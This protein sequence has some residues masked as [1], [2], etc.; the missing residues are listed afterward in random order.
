[1]SYL[2]ININNVRGSL[3]IF[4]GTEDS[5]WW[6]KVFVAGWMG[7]FIDGD[8]WMGELVDI[9]IVYLWRVDGG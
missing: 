5:G 1:M 9:L 7:G 4:T 3:R 2:T 8:L 6:I